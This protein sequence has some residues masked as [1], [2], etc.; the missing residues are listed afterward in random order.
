MRYKEDMA[1]LQARAQ[2][3]VFRA[4]V[5]EEIIRAL[6]A[7]KREAEHL[8]MPYETAELDSRAFANLAQAAEGAVQRL[9]C[10]HPSYYTWHGESRCGRCGE[11]ET[12]PA[13]PF[14]DQ[15]TKA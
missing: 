3:D 2:D 7:L 4:I 15:E 13:N 11:P 14:N 10:S 9:T 5:R 1:K 6:G 12:M 8:D